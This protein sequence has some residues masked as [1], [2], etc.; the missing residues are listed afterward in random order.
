MK[1]A[2][3]PNKANIAKTLIVYMGGA[4]VI[5]EAINFLLDKYDLNAAILDV[6]ILLV[7]FGLPAI[8]IYTW[9]QQKFTRKAII[10]QAINGVIALAV[11]VFTL[12]N[13]GKLDP[14]QLRLLKFKDNQKQLAESIQSL[15]VLPFDNYTGTDEFDYY[16][17]GM[18]SGLIGDLGKISALRVLS[19]TTSR[20]FKDVDM[21]I[22][23]IASEL[24]VDAVIEPSI[25][26][27]GGDSVCVQIKLV[28]AFPKE[29]QLWVQNYRIEKSQILN[30]YNNVT[31]KI[32]EE[33]N[34]VLTPQEEDLLAESK[35][36]NSEAYDLYLKGLYYWDQFTPEALQLALEY[37]NKSIETDPEWAQPY[38]GVAYY[39]V[40][41]HQFSL[42][43]SSVTI[44]N[45]FEN[46]N[47][48]IEL[49]PN[50]SFVHYCSALVN[51][52]TAWNWEKAEQEF[53]KVLEMN[54]NYAFGHMYYAHLLSC[55]RRNDEAVSHCR[56]ALD[57]DPLN[58]MIQALSTLVLASAG[59]YKEVISMAEKALSIVPDH[60][61]ALANL[62]AIYAIIGEYRKSIELWTTY[63][64]LDED[65]RKSI[66]L[67]FDQQGIEA[68]L[69]E[70]ITKL[71]LATGDNLPM[72]L[73]QLNAWLGDEAKALSW[74]EKG[75]EAHHPMMPYINTLFTSAGPFKIDDPGFDSLILKMNLPLKRNE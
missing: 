56:T 53:L 35:T 69:K 41:V 14:T 19:K 25:S 36:I 48:A 42:A 37:F 45:M 64:Y 71:E 43:P 6:F 17:A 70:F 74:Y 63:L 26:C 75:Y 28:S 60:P 55:L 4:W 16:V 54:P 13:P 47:K 57:L 68:A 23:E 50:S 65:A 40:A 27:V 22:P 34:I 73:G 51:G 18:H 32:S 30:F 8:L 38:A 3:Q 44:P 5:I 61:V 46:L 24:G 66:L 2:E 31:R 1:Q 52:W 21:T 39:W 9:F 49:D 12:V 72:E 59:E 10:L 58:P 33:I 67:T 62:A 20:F 11:I 15:A 7:I 29:Q